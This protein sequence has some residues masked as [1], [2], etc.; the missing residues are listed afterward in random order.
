MMNEEPE[1]IY[2]TEHQE[3]KETRHDKSNP[4]ST[5]TSYLSSGTLTPFC[6]SPTHQFSF[7]SSQSH[8]QSPTHHHHHQNL[9][10]KFHS[11][12][13]RTYTGTS[14]IPSSNDSIFSKLLSTLNSFHIKII[15]KSSF[16]QTQSN[17]I[18]IT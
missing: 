5:S 14:S 6:D 10:Y 16:I 15:F 17:P 7:N 1:S 13:T 8:S 3:I 2:E 11:P 4:K 18:T 9:N 12:P